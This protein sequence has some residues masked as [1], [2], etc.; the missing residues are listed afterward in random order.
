MLLVESNEIRR[1]CAS[2]ICDHIILNVKKKRLIAHTVV[3]YTASTC[4]KIMFHDSF[5][6][7]F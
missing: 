7:R 1:E 5:D 2:Y 3:R 4:Q 6:D